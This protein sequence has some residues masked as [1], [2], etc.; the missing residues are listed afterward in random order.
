MSLLNPS[1]DV[2][3]NL[4]WIYWGSMSLRLSTLEWVA[5]EWQPLGIYSHLLL[6]PLPGSLIEGID[7]QVMGPSGSSLNFH[8]A[9][10]GRW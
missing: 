4:V 9:A 1:K 2:F 8:I 10:V 3:N 6:W 7:R 5:Y